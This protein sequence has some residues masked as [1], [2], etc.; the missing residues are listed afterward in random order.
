M[1]EQELSNLLT[2]PLNGAKPTQLTKFQG[3]QIFNF[4]WSHDGKWLALARGRVAD[5]LVLITDAR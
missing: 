5:D 4:A 1:R 2:Q 3:E